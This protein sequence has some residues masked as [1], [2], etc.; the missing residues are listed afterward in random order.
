MT[1]VSTAALAAF[2]GAT[3]IIHPAMAEPT[4]TSPEDAAAAETAAKKSGRVKRAATPGVFEL[5]TIIVT[6]GDQSGT[7]GQVMSQSVV[8]SDDVR[9]QNRDTLDDALRTVPGVEIGNTGGSRN[10]RLIFVRGFERW[11]VPLYVDGVRIYLPADNRIDFGRFL[12][13]DLSEIQVQ[14]GYV[15]VLNGPGGMG[16][17]INLVTRKPTKAFE[18][19]LQ[20]GVDLGNTG[21][22]AG[23]RTFAS[24]GMR[25]DL[26]YLQASGSVKDS[27]G[28]F[29]SRDFASNLAEDGGRRD[30]SDVTDWRGNIKFGFTPN[31]TDEYV[32]SYTKQS[33]KKG[34]P[35]AV[36]QPVRGRTPAPYGIG[37]SYQ[38]DWTWPYWDISSLSFN[39]HT[40]VGEES[41]LETK[42]YYNT[43][44]NLLSAYDDSTFT[45]QTQNRAFDSYYADYAYGFSVLGATDLIPM[46]SLKAAVHYRLDNHGEWQ[47]S[48][49]DVSS[50][51]EP[52]QTQIEATWSVAAEDTFHVTEDVDLVGGISY[53]ANKLTRAE[54]YRNNAI[55]N[56]PLGGSSAFNWQAAA[57]WRPSDVTTLHASVSS[58]TRF[59]TIFERFS[60]RFGTA[61]PN[62]DLRPERAT[63]FEVGGSTAVTD[64]LRLSG[65][66]FYS[67]VK[68]AIQSIGI[69]GGLVQN[70]NIGNGR[71]Y[72]VEASVAWDATSTVTI[73]ANYTYLRREIADPVRPNLRSTGVPE[74]LGYLYVNWTPIERFTANANLELSSSRWSDNPAQTDYIKVPGFAIANVN[75]E[76]AFSDMFSTIFGV[77]NVFDTDYELT[78]GFPEP[79]RTFYLS[80]RLVF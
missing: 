16:G 28:W 18:A 75:F 19:E 33:G 71:Y 63:N 7:S 79:G 3:A 77:R 10:E 52:E 43:F 65:A 47:H 11:Q 31:A 69:G 67:D 56:Y 66:I 15:S 50:F 37:T 29:L 9:S 4:A 21:E 55:F 2:L 40:A 45:T 23:F 34:A 5:G 68:D 35:Y 57:I 32:V 46:N 20:T 61:E 25:Q 1:R 59:P 62:P 13:P 30:F 60:T 17:A 42:A 74:H 44:D 12:T 53:D 26:Y 49:P 54:D 80:G 48:R 76:Y 70:Q 8:T 41:Y 22:L 72:G 24:V 78:T 58:R 64:G 27:D 51:V 73:G 38:R 36:N 39:S 14:K 6:G